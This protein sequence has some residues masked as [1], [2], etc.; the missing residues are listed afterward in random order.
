MVASKVRPRAHPQLLP[1]AYG[2]Y[3]QR[4]ARQPKLR[5]LGIFGMLSS[6]SRLKA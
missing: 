2:G 6:Q 5:C 3:G 4:E 1:Y